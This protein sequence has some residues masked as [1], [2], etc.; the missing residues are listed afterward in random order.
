MART[1][2][3]A[4][5]NAP[6][7]LLAGV[8]GLVMLAA[9]SGGGAGVN[10]HDIT[11]ESALIKYGKKAGRLEGTVKRDWRPPI[12]WVNLTGIVIHNTGTATAGE[13]AHKKFT[14]H[15]VVPLDGRV[16][17]I[18]PL[19]TYLASSDGFNSYTIA[20]SVVG[21]YGDGHDM[22]PAQAEGLRRA[23]AYAKAVAEANGSDIQHLWTHRQGELGKGADPGR[24]PYQVAVA[25]ARAL[26]MSHDPD[27]TIDDG[28][29]IPDKWS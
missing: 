5:T 22:P 10:V 7:M 11:G 3:F 8:A 12:P 1:S 13:G 25:Q 29:S 14:Y 26:G 16:V 27:A 17:L 23:I 24:A 28:R 19:N 4:L 21:K 9:S 6:W 2:D 20:I 15:I 18:H